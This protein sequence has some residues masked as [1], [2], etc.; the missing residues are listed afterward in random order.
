MPSATVQASQN[1]SA[2][3]WFDLSAWWASVSVKPEV[4]RMIVLSSGMPIAPIGVN[5][6]L[7][8]GPTEGQP[9]ANSGQRILES[10]AP[11]SG[12]ESTRM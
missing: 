9:A 7:T 4:S 3:R 8:Y 6:V 12:T 11:R 5:C 2:P 1:L 10:I